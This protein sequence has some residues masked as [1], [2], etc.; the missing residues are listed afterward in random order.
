M[1]FFILLVL[2]LGSL[3]GYALK[4][5]KD[6][7]VALQKAKKA[8]KPLLVYLYMLNCNTCEY[9][10][11]KVFKEKK[12]ISYLRKN[13]VV[14]K[15]YA[16]DKSLPKELQADMSPVFHFINAQNGEMIESIMGGRKPDKFLKQLQNSYDDYKEETN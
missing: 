16:N 13:Y 3:H 7:T 5:E 11:K 2:V 4:V 15:L 9:M 8:H 12:V 6:Y 14:V 1:K 10:N